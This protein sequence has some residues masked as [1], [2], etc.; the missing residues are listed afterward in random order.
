MLSPVSTQSGSFERTP[1]LSSPGDASIETETRTATTDNPQK[2]NAKEV[3]VKAVPSS[4][5]L[6][7]KKQSAEYSLAV[8]R[9][10]ERQF[11]SLG[12]VATY[13]NGSPMHRK[14]LIKGDEKIY[15]THKARGINALSETGQDRVMNVKPREATWPSNAEPG[16]L[17]DDNLDT[18]TAALAETP[19][20][21]NLRR[22]VKYG[23]GPQVRFANEASEFIYGKSG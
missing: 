20:N 23:L 2:L 19:S 10:S 13:K 12:H 7:L 15:S 6:G 9:T 1:S 14:P 8:P 11:A 16:M 18:P 3:A 5:Q 21:D 17:K 22:S 4:F